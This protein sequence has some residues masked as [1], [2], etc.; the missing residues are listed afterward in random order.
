MHSPEKYADIPTKT[1]NQPTNQPPQVV[2]APS[3]AVP[4]AGY[5]RPPNRREQSLREK[6]KTQENRGRFEDF[7]QIWKKKDAKS[8]D[9]LFAC[10]SF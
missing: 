1:T 4:A 7:L 9:F 10:I 8:D 3:W 5:V 6:K 2:E